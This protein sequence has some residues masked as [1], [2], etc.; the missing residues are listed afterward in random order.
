MDRA[1]KN[2]NG[3]PARDPLSKKQNN[4]QVNVSISTQKVTNSA[5]SFCNSD[6]TSSLSAKKVKGFGSKV[7]YPTRNPGPAKKS[8]QPSVFKLI[9]ISLS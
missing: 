9:L 7:S 3:S 1:E 2:E 5:Y 6:I 8:L 4:N